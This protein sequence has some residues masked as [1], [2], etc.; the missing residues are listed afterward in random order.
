ME[1]KDLHRQINAKL[2]LITLQLTDEDKL[3]DPKVSAW[4]TFK[5]NTILMPDLSAGTQHL[6][7]ESTTVANHKLSMQ[8]AQSCVLKKSC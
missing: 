2:K 4:I 8:L 5:Y 1:D 6:L 7:L 3:S